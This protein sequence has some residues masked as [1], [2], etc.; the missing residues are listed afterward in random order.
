LSEV[1]LQPGGRTVNDVDLPRGFVW[2]GN[3]HIAGGSEFS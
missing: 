2:Y 3:V 1:D